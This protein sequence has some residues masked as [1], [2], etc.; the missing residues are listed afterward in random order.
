MFEVLSKSIGRYVDTSNN[1]NTSKLV[2]KHASIGSQLAMWSDCWDRY[3]FEHLIHDKK[4][5]IGVVLVMKHSLEDNNNVEAFVMEDCNYLDIDVEASL[6]FVK[7]KFRNNE[8]EVGKEKTANK[9]L[10]AVGQC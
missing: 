4:L 5:N 10:E 7:V 6:Y 2:E 3:L 1:Y 9:L 8:Y